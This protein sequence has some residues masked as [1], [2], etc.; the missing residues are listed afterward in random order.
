MF[1]PGLGDSV[2]IP[3]VAKLPGSALNSDSKLVNLSL[4][5]KTR[6]KHND[7]EDEAI[8][9]TFESLLRPEDVFVDT[10]VTYVRSIVVNLSEVL[11]PDFQKA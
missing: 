3:S 8:L 7:G 5:N 6:K 4:C 1:S 9:W 2:R 11:K 10:K